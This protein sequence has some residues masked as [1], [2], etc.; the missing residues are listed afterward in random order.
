MRPNDLR[1]HTWLAEYFTAEDNKNNY[2]F[3]RG[4]KRSGVETTARHD[5]LLAR[6]ICGGHAGVIILPSLVTHRPDSPTGLSPRRYT[7]LPYFLTDMRLDPLRNR[8]LTTVSWKFNVLSTIVFFRSCSFIA[9]YSEVS[10]VLGF[11]CRVAR[12]GYSRSNGRCRRR[13]HV[14]WMGFGPEVDCSRRERA[15][16]V[17]GCKPTRTP[18][19]YGRNQ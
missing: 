6:H 16:S 17:S 12:P 1:T 15:A 5:S 10:A 9:T 7:G 4:P 3:L 18:G 19:Q 13:G 14:F 8:H 2:I 11:M